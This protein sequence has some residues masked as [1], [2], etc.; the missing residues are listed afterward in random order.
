[1]ISSVLSPPIDVL[2]AFNK[3]FTF[4]DAFLAKKSTADFED[5]IEEELE[6]VWPEWL[7]WFCCC[8]FWFPMPIFEEDDLNESKWS[9]FSNTGL[10]FGVRDGA[11]PCCFWASRAAWILTVSGTS[12]KIELNKEQIELL[13]S[14]VPCKNEY[15]MSCLTANAELIK[16]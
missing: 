5:L 4:P 15:L 8:W 10:W 11:I 14:S 1:M 7:G 6:E 16:K 13:L 2:L 9:S 12:S 3:K